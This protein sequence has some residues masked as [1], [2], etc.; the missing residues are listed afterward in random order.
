MAWVNRQPTNPGITR[1]QLAGALERLEHE[2][3]EAD[4]LGLEVA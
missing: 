1:T 4:Q 2:D 3:R